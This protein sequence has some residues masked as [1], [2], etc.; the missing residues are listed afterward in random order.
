MYTHAQTQSQQAPLF[1][2]I[3]P[4]ILNSKLNVIGVRVF[5]RERTESKG[6]QDKRRLKPSDLRVNNGL[7]FQHTLR[8]RHAKYCTSMPAA[9]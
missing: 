3:E 6:G 7:A 2:I 8:Y 4:I 5:R 9:R 1:I